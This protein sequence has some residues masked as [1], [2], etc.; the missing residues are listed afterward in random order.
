MII[1]GDDGRDEFVCYQVQWVKARKHHKCGNCFK[2]IAAGDMYE[3]SIVWCDRYDIVRSCERCSYGDEV[4]FGCFDYLLER[5]RSAEAPTKKE[6]R[7]RCGDDRRTTALRVRSGR[8]NA[9]AV[10]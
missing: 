5:L 3:R 8:H 2:R 7:L 10:R 6:A 1:R 9:M 4:V